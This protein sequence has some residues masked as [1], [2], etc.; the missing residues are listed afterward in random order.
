MLQQ[1]AVGGQAARGNHEVAERENA[2]SDERQA[3]AQEGVQR[4]DGGDPEAGHGRERAVQHR[5]RML[6]APRSAHEQSEALAGDD[7]TA[8]RHAEPAGRE[9][10]RLRGENVQ[11]GNGAEKSQ[12]GAERAAGEAWELQGELNGRLGKLRGS[13]WTSM[14]KGRIEKFDWRLSSDTFGCETLP[15]LIDSG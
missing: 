1:A 13:G 6:A 8:G 2:L 15:T 10:D 14:L 4:A 9:D 3:G 5:G 7:S 11:E 12:L